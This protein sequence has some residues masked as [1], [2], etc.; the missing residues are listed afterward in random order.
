MTPIGF[1]RTEVVEASVGA[2]ESREDDE[3]VVK[4]VSELQTDDGLLNMLGSRLLGA[5]WLETKENLSKS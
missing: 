2:W 5:V 3:A 4:A 1:R